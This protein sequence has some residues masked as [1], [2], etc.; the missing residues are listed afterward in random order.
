MPVIILVADGARSD[1]LAEAID[2]GALPALARLRA[3]GAAHTVTSTFPSV[4]GPAYAPFLLGRYPGPIGLPALRWFDRTRSQASFPHYTRSYVGHEM[5]HV[6]RDLAADAPT[7]F[8][9]APRSLGSLSVIQRGLAKKSRLGAGPRFAIRA[10]RTHFSGDAARWLDIDREMGREVA[11][12]VRAERPDF[13][14]AAL[15]GIDK[16]SHAEGHDHGLVVDAMRI[17]DDVVAELRDDAERGGWWDETHLWVVSDHGHSPVSWHDDLASVLEEAGSRVVAHPWVYRAHPDAAVMVSGNAMAHIYLDLDA[18]E[19]P[20]WPALGARWGEL[21]D[22]LVQRP[23]VDIALL[24]QSPTRCEVVSATRGRA[25]VSLAP[26]AGGCMTYTY[27]TVTGDPLGIG[28][29][30]VAVN[31]DD[32]WEATI[33]TDYPDSVVQ[34][35]HLAGASRSGEIILSA[36]REW[37][38]RARYEPIPH[39]SSHGALHREHMLVPLIVN[40]PPG[41]TPRRTVDVMPSA[42]AALG[43]PNPPGLDG[44]SFLDRSS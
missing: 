22:M 7:L 44:R 38:F 18:A 9:L 12:R 35:A 42:L 17:V 4:T 31:G 21:C 30:L 24:P 3:E 13:V 6:D 8:E 40:R 41:R 29:E 23:S 14:F 10:A 34:V 5:R 20:W 32:A 33:E 2:S 15:T 25:V 1:S 16:A 36:T 26:T 19:R 43:I 11:S 37:D 39:R 28:D 27:R